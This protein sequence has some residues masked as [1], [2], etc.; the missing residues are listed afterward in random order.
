MKA[1]L[2][3]KYGSPD[4]LTL[5]EIDQPTPGDNQVLVKVHAAATNPSNWHR[6]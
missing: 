4:V 1:I 6:M 3:R 5:E 2:A